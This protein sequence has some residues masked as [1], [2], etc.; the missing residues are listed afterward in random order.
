MIYSSEDK[1]EWAFSLYDLDNN[2]QISRDE[3]LA[4]LKD[5]LTCCDFFNFGT[6]K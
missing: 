2:G 4:I 3:M 6:Y 5:T 1:L